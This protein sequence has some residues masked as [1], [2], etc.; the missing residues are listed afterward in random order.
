MEPSSESVNND[1]RVHTRR[2][3]MENTGKSQLLDR[4][5]RVLS[6]KLDNVVGVRGLIV[7]KVVR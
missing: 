7:N 5:L 2:V 4:S 3:E 6:Q 1:V